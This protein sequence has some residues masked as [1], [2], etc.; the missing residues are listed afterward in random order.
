MDDFLYIKSS[1]GFSI[2][3]STL[4]IC[5][6][7]ISYDLHFFNH[8]SLLSHLTK[9]KKNPIDNELHIC[10]T[11]MHEFMY[12]LEV[13]LFSY[14]PIFITQYCIATSNLYCLHLS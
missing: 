3:S 9:S 6:D 12:W 5:L 4:C 8:N 13:L 14:L 10:I 2:L 11:W 7:F 1:I